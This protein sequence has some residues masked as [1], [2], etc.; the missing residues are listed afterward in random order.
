M[1]KLFLFVL[2][3][4]TIHLSAQDLIVTQDGETIKAYHTDVADR[5]VYYQLEDTD[6]APVLKIRKSDVLVIKLQSGEVVLV[7]EKAPQPSEVNPPV[8]SAI[9]L[10]AEPV[11]DPDRVAAA[12]I[13]SLIEFYDGSKGVVFYLDGKGHGL[14]VNLYHFTDY[15]QNASSWRECIDIEAIP[16]GINMSVQMG[17]GAAYCDAATRQIGKEKLPVIYWCRSFGPDWYLPSLGELNELLVVSNCS[18]GTEGPISQVLKANG[19]DPIQDSFYYY[20]SS[21]DDDTNIF[22]ILGS[23]EV[24]IVKKYFPC[25]CRAIRMF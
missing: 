13:G 10:P 6:E 16:N 14:A 19:G 1:K 3:A 2:L 15:W 22:S 17:L 12:Q 25:P 9:K 21:E 8:E 23:G 11:A 7:Q 20:S 24:T 18:N 4:T 5:M